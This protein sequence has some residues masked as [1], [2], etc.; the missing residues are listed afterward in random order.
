MHYRHDKLV[1]SPTD[2]CRFVES[3][4]ASWMDRLFLEDPQRFTPDPASADLELIRRKGNDLEDAYIASLIESGE[5]VY[6]PREERDRVAA[7]LE[8]MRRG[9]SMIQQASLAHE[10]LAGYPDLLIRVEGAS[11]LGDHHYI[12]RDVKL[13]LSAKP[14]YILQLC[15]YVE[16]LEAMQG[17]RPES[18]ELL[19]G[20]QELVSLR[21]ADHFHYYLEQKRAFLAFHDAFDAERQPV[22]AMGEDHVQWTGEATAYLERIDHLSRVANIRK[23][24]IERLEAAGITTMAALAASRDERIPKLN[25]AQ[26]Q[27]LRRQAQLQIESAEL[28][29]PSYEILIPDASG[30][31]RGLSLL[32][33]ESRHDIYFDMEGYPMMAGG[34]EYLFGASYYE[35]GQLRFID[36]WGHDREQEKRAFEGFIDWA[37]ARWRAD[38]STHIYHYAHY[39][40]TAL[41]RLMSTHGTREAQ[42]DQLLRNSVFIDLYTVV[43]HGLLVGEPKYSIKNL[44]HLF[45]ER[46][47]GD[48][49]SAV[50]SIVEYQRFIDSGEPIDWSKSPILK[51]I[52]DY[53]K[54]DCDSTAELA[55]WLRA[56]Q[57]ESGIRYRGKPPVEAP[58]DAE[59]EL[60]EGNRRRQELAHRLLLGESDS[61]G[62]LLG[63]LVEFHRREDKPKWWELYRRHEM[64]DDELAEDL[65]CLGG[66]QRIEGSQHSIKYSTGIRYRFDP[67]QD[68]KLDVGKQFHLAHDLDLEGKIEE[69]DRE[70][71]EVT[72]CF[73]PSTTKKEGWPPPAKLSLIPAE[74]IPID[75][76]QRA[77]ERQA[78][79]WER[80]GTLPPALENFLNRRHPS[81][82]GHDDGPI[83]HDRETPSDGCVRVV[84]QM[85]QSTLSIQG[86]PGTGKTYTAARTIL[87]L[88]ERGKRVGITSN[89]HKAILNL[90]AKCAELHGGTLR[91][92][93]V[94]GD[95]NDPLLAKVPGVQCSGGGRDGAANAR[96]HSLIGGT[97]WLFSHEAMREA[98]DYLFIDEAGQ[99]SLA[100]LV[101]MAASTHNLVLVGDQMQL[102]QPSQAVHP[103]DSGDSTLEYLLADEP[104]IPPEQGVFLD[105]SYRLH[106]E[107]CRVNSE[108]FYQGKLH[109]APGCERRTIGTEKSAGIVFVPVEH[110]GNTQGSDEEAEVVRQLFAKLQGVDYTGLDGE[111]AGKL[112]VADVLVV[113]P[114]NM[115]V[116]KL[117]DVLPDGARVGSV[118]KFQGQEAPVVIISMCASE[119]HDS[120]R[121]IE[122]LLNPNRLNVAL[123]R[124]QSLAYVVGHPGLARTRCRTPEQ[125]KLVNL[126][127]RLTQVGG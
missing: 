11:D 87:E 41:K 23:T 100:N 55:H 95:R 56:R 50:D 78:L 45:R 2:I 15:A 92:L 46:R 26:F 33:P 106:P 47:D 63:H 28:E 18:C 4:F 10:R 84:P 27:R 9:E 6:D 98:V 102:G 62:R 57:Q 42:L 37:Y 101:A 60:S 67:D 53:N 80:H 127:C 114:Y 115:Q 21:T 59:E 124:A 38:P 88:I 107:I 70:A 7:T 89:S 32:P 61:V 12:P 72:L 49:Q 34:L 24:Q 25:A 17:R 73:S 93:K 90:M 105:L 108:A 14:K 65:A 43:R 75:P 76:L 94:G 22:P 40:T 19:L 30:A 82:A 112:G 123:S 85:Q 77:I 1:F 52:R 79:E 109:S 99:V 71:G 120:P 122:F 110:Q 125:M 44:E 5:T 58:E 117:R 118:D 68:T 81:I 97:A 36:W 20:N 111:I 86:P 121:G 103:E 96:A 8:A 29:R 104:T 31:A 116:R 13:G 91:C 16:M 51:G 35:N 119:G 126:Y 74:F 3:H 113:A 39:E 48:V 64:S 66:L 83:L 54:D 69:I